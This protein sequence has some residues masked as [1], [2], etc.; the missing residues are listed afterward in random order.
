MSVS[1]ENYRFFIATMVK[2]NYEPKDILDLLQSAW[3]KESPSA[4]T[5]YRICKDV[6]DNQ[7]IKWTEAARSGRPVEALTDDNI[8]VVRF[9]VTE[10]PHVS[11]LELHYITGISTG[12]VFTLLHDRL[13]LKSL[14]S[15]WI[16]KEL[17]DAQKL[18]RVAVARELLE[19]FTCG[20]QQLDKIFWIDEKWFYL[21]AIGNKNTNKVWVSSATEKPGIARRSQGE[22]KC[23]VIMAV[24]LGGH[25]YFEIVPHNQSVNS[26][27]YISFLK[28]MHSKFS[29]DSNAL[30]WRN[31]CLIHD[32]ARPHVSK[33]VTDFLQQKRLRVIRQAPYSPDYNLLDR[34]M[35]NKLEN[36]RA[37]QNFQTCDELREFLSASLASMNRQTFLGQCEKLKNDL[38]GVINAY[39]NYL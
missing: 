19:L 38:T 18:H 29:H 35:F 1:R 25:H 6:K 10:N 14:C 33:L 17:N 30:G 2:N 13:N 31:G 22:A 21:R 11:V 12:S 3:G 20:V 39:G 36:M 7:R 27:V 15:K 8:E 5:V 24:S 9:I 16:P 26:E 28:N 32:N 23:H 37:K 34:W 4:A